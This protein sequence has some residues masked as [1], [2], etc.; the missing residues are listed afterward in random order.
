MHVENMWIFICK[1]PNIIIFSFC[2]TS[3][4][5]PSEW[6]KANVVPVHKKSGKQILENYGLISLLPNCGKILNDYCIKACLRF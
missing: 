6:K 3:G 1:P 2:I 5:F 4:K